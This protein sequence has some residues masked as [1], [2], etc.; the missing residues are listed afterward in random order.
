MRDLFPGYYKPSDTDFEIMWRN[1]IFVFDT[2]V[3]LDLYRYSEETVKSLMQIIDVLKDRIWIPYQVSNEYHKNL[4]SVIV[5]QVSRYETS[6]KTLTDFK[7]QIDEKRNH[8]FLTE[9]L[10]QEILLFC[11]KFDQELVSKK[12][13]VIEL[14]SN[15][16]IKENLASLL[17]QRVG[18]PLSDKQKEEIFFEGEKRYANNIPPGYSDKKK[19]I[20]ERY[21]DLI[22]WKEILEKNKNSSSPIIF[23]TGDHKED[24]FLTLMGKIVGPRPELV[25]EFKKCNNNLFYCYSTDK[26]LEYA[27]KYL[28]AEINDETLQEVEALISKNRDNETEAENLENINE[29]SVNSTE[30]FDE[31]EGEL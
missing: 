21:G 26:F 19:N 18:N 27:K 29:L 20:P 12:S 1:G 3:L 30:S 25:D 14:I 6:I 31:T 28:N 9:E 22:V 2:N 7:K 10:H 4:N 24:W 23:I 8:P 15:N 11:S 17:H 13:Q 5:Q 16:P